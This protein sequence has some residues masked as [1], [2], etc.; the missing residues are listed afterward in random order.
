MDKKSKRNI[1]KSS[2]CDIKINSDIY[3][4]RNV[5]ERKSNEKINKLLRRVSSQKC[6]V[7]NKKERSQK[8]EL[9]EKPNGLMSTAIMVSYSNNDKKQTDKDDVKPCKPLKGKTASRKSKK[10]LNKQNKNIVSNEI[11]IYDETLEEFKSSELCS[12]IVQT[13]NEREALDSSSLF[14]L[15]EKK[16]LRVNS[17]LPVLVDTMLLEKLVRLDKNI[18][19][20]LI[21]KV[22]KQLDEVTLPNEELVNNLCYYPDGKPDTFNDLD[23]TA[24]IKTKENKL[25]KKI[26]IRKFL[27]NQI[28]NLLL[29]RLMRNKE[30]PAE[31]LFYLILK[32]V[33]NKNS[34]ENDAN[35]DV[36]RVKDKIKEY[37]EI[38]KEQLKKKLVKQ[39]K[40]NEVS[41]VKK[42]I[43][44][45]VKKKQKKVNEEI[46]KKTESTIRNNRRNAL[47]HKL[48]KAH[49][50]I[51]LT[52]KEKND[53]Q[54]KG[55]LSTNVN[56]KP[57]VMASSDVA[58]TSS[59]DLS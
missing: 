27:I 11:E 52:D 45:S 41:N 44:K 38:R 31:I 23:F 20:K 13:Q 7:E 8:A 37:N 33:T 40:K 16:I 22:F 2:R 58:D 26:S 46:V 32:F 18:A 17:Y 5:K 55:Y 24:V 53:K 59:S 15:A 30:R 25:N 49:K 29:S 36:K 43:K 14:S 51:V 10:F 1:Y 57:L 54:I 50:G 9:T 12:T 35:N 21:M 19:K 56:L 48:L 34:K 39:S 4:V 42:K 3:L 47:A 6:I 28:Y